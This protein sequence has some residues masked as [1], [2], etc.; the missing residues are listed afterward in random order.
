MRLYKVKRGIIVENEGS[1]FLVED[2][3][4][5]QFFNDNNLL[6]KAR[7]IVDSQKPITNGAEIIDNE[8]EAPI[9]SQEIWAAG[10]TYFSSKLG[11][12]A[13]THPY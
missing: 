9:Q 8:L 4:W 11:R 5:D 1:Y 2:I 10:V 13:A 7:G 6:N 12:Q 3:P